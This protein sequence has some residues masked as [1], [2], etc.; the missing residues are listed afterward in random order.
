[1]W[2]GVI[3]GCEWGMCFIFPCGRAILRAGMGGIGWMDGRGMEPLNLVVLGI[4]LEWMGM[5]WDRN[6][7]RIQSESK[8]EIKK[9]RRMGRLR[10][11]E[12]VI[13]RS[14]TNWAS[15]VCFRYLGSRG[16]R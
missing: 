11:R 14:R 13:E 8:K 9:E 2:C 3:S 7:K 10:S 5:G 16:Y 6:T 4:K 12:H 1:M 15:C